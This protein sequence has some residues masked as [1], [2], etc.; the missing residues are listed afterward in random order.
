M[1]LGEARINASE[2][3]AHAAKVPDRL[4][5]SPLGELHSQRVETAEHGHPCDFPLQLREVGVRSAI[6]HCLAHSRQ[7]FQTSGNACEN[8]AES[9][10]PQFA[11]RAS[12]S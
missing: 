12:P 9:R 4:F 2:L 3:L 11:S 10:R 5:P 1:R 7:G 8:R 6:F